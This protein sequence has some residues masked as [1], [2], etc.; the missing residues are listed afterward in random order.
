MAVQGKGTEF[1]LRHEL[2]A[3]FLEHPFELCHRLHNEEWLI[4]LTYLGGVFS[5]VNELMQTIKKTHNFLHAT[6][7][8]YMP[9]SAQEAL[10]EI[11]TSGFNKYLLNEC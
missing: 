10:V 2:K 3:V 6:A 1:E 8:T 4:I 11:S 7:H 9:I 5:C